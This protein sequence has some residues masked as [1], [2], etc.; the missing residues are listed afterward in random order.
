MTLARPTRPRPWT[1]NNAIS[2]ATVGFGR[3]DTSLS[4]GPGGAMRGQ[5]VALRTGKTVRDAADAF[6]ARSTATTTRRS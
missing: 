6:L 1:S 2:A 5:L 4:H 3:T